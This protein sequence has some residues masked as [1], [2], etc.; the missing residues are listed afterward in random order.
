M[1]IGR[2]RQSFMKANLG[3]GFASPV[4]FSPGGLKC[5]VLVF[6]LG[7][8]Q[9]LT[10]SLRNGKATTSILTCYVNGIC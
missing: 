10:S 6:F 9:P 2:Y 4:S 7:G 3:C 5:E 1:N 8:F